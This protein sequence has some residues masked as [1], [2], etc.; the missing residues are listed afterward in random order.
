[1]FD[2]RPADWIIINAYLF[3]ARFDDGLNSEIQVNPEF[4]SVPAAQGV[5]DKYARMI[6]QLPTVLRTR[7]ETVWIHKGEELWGGGNDNIL[8]HVD[9]YAYD[10]DFRDF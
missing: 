5:A 1:M 7:V 8:I 10:P 4:E 3:N 9:Q 2:R 6:G